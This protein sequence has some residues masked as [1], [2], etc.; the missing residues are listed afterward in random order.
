[1]L[2][3]TSL[4]KT[5]MLDELRFPSWTEPDNGWSRIS[6]WDKVMDPISYPHH[7]S[8]EKA[9]QFCCVRGFH[10]AA[11]GKPMPSQV[12]LFRGLAPA[13]RCR[14]AGSNYHRGEQLCVMGVATSRPTITTLFWWSTDLRDPAARV[15][16]LFPVDTYHTTLTYVDTGMCEVDLP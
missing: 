16:W 7:N 3:D 2:G 11:G 8:A 15:S 6:S 10:F 5:F 12:F 1:M 9:G 13:S 4:S 14:N